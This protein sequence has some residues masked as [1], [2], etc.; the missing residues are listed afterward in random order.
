MLMECMQYYLPPL[1]LLPLHLL[2]YL[3]VKTLSYL[4][5]YVRVVAGVLKGLGYNIYMDEGSIGRRLDERKAE[6]LEAAA[7]IVVFVSKK[8]HELAIV[9]TYT[10]YLS[11]VRK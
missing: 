7:V 1:Y 10:T 3:C 2:V 4:E 9:S 6:A 8:Y 11:F 5:Q